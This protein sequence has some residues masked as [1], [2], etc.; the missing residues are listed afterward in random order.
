MEGTFLVVH[1]KQITKKNIQGVWYLGL[2]VWVNR[3]V[4]D[5]TLRTDFVTQHDSDSNT[6]FTSTC[7]L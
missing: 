6:S 3:P 4:S 1:D 5:L 2:S 7:G